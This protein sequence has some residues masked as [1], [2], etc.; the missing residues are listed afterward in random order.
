MSAPAVVLAWGRVDA[1]GIVGS[2]RPQV[3]WADLGVAAPGDGRTFRRVFGERDETFRRLDRMSRVLVLAG[4]AAGIDQVLTPALAAGAAIVFETTVGSLDADLRFADSMAAG[5]CDGPV[6]AYTL[7]SSSLG[8]L[9]LRHGLRGP[10]VCMST[11]EAQPGVALREAGL[12]LAAGEV[13]VA[14]VGRID[15][16]VGSRPTVTPICRAVVAVLVRASLGLRGVA[17]WPDAASDPWR[18]WPSIQGTSSDNRSG[19]I[20]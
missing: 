4:A 2:G 7:P 6:F 19:R 14:V 9:A 5:L 13:E 3:R 8:E 17:A 10:T 1:D 15:V 16:L 20:E 18:D 11:V 12:M